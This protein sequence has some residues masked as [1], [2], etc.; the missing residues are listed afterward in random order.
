MVSVPTVLKTSCNLLI[1]GM[2]DSIYEMNK[3]P[4]QRQNTG[5]KTHLT[6]VQNVAWFTIANTVLR[7]LADE[8]LSPKIPFSVVYFF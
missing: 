7:Q 8:S 5:Q 2:R 1:T 6:G 3:T 4:D